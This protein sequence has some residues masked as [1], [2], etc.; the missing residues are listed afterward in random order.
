[1]HAIRNAAMFCLAVLFLIPSGCS[2]PRPDGMPELVQCTVVL[3]YS[4][5]KPAEGVTV[6][7]NS[8][9]PA[10]LKW[11]SAGV[12]DSSG[13]AK[14]VTYGQYPGAP[15]GEFKVMLKKI[16][17]V[18]ETNS[19]DGSEGQKEP[20][21][22]YSLVGTDFTKPETTPLTLT[23]GKKSVSETF[24]IGEEKRELVDRFVPGASL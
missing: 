11:P 23:V 24:D 13:K 15:E 8:D 6:V 20:I 21:E 22:Y 5:G 3:K 4:D 12:T 7:L 17:I 9:S 18:G 14:I 16:E 19:D 10:L 1:M 2:K